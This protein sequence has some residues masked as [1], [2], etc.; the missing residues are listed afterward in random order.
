LRR[1]ATSAETPEASSFASAVAS[2][3]RALSHQC[4]EARS[5]R[6]FAQGPDDED[7][8][9][10]DGGHF[11]WVDDELGDV[12]CRCFTVFIFLASFGLLLK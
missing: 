12:I 9:V 2:K 1:S 5:V 8:I 4:I 7:D 11:I 10:G 6:L 3:L